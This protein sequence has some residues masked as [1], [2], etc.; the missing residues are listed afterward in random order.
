VLE[1]KPEISVV[2]PTYN[3]AYLIGRAIQSVLQQTFQDIEVLLVDD[4]SNDNTKEIVAGIGDN[5]IKYIRHEKNRGV[6]AARNTGIAS[7][8]GKYVAFLDSDDEWLPEK[9]EKQI[10]VFT[11]ATAAV[12]IVYT[13]MVILEG[14]NKKYIPPVYA[15]SREGNLLRDLLVDPI[16]VKPPATMIR[17][18]CFARVGMFDE[19]FFAGEDWDLWIRLAKHYEFKYINDLLV[20]CHVLA[21][22]VTNSNQ[23]F[24]YGRIREL[25]LEKHGEDIKKD[26]HVLSSYYVKMGHDFCTEQQLNKG[27]QYFIQAARAFPFNIESPIIAYLATLLGQTGYNYIVAQY[28]KFRE[29]LFAK[30]QK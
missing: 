24:T 28:R 12:G 20:I 17:K 14:N 1:N 3:R 18:E 9:L 25:I 5:R 22:R 15:K 2:I 19:N 10:K 30:R 11:D 29:W 27:R 26:R 23:N 21:D 4:C 7:A 16:L 6:A 8:T 13:R